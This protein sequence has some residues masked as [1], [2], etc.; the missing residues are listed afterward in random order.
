MLEA[1]ALSDPG[2][3]RSSNQDAFRIVP[4]AGL[5][6]VADGMGG[7]RG[8]ETAS[9]LAVESV[10]AAVI[11]APRRDAAAL[12]NAV[13]GAN[14]Q[15]YS[16]ASHDPALEGMGTT[17]V[18]VLETNP[19]ELAIASVGDSRVY[20]FHEGSLKAITEDQ[21]WVQEVG[22]QLGLDEASLKKHPMRHVLTMAL[23][24]SPA[25]RIRYYGTAVQPGDLMLL[26]SDGLHGVVPEAVIAR[27]L[28]DYSKR[29]G[30]GLEPACRELLAAA[31]AAGSPDNVTVLV[32]RRAA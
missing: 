24:V 4:E 8:G 19:G 15:V 17:L 16:Q 6:L 7:A 2:K 13:E 14:E 23:G 27:I 9:R 10:S 25:I 1:Y 29:D 28:G 11:N 26:S 31:N 20:L 30:S 5:Y 32:L 18:A 3:V 12:L 21:S 22:R